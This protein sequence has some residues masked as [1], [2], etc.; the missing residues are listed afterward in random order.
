MAAIASVCDRRGVLCHV[1]GVQ[2]L[3]HIPVDLS[4]IPCD[5]YV[6]ASH[7]F[8]GPRGCGGVFLR[9][10][11]LTPLMDGGTQEWGLRPG[12]EDLPSLA[13]AVAALQRSLA[14]LPTEAPRLRDL[15]RLVLDNVRSSGVACEINGEPDHGLPGL[16]SLTFPGVNGHALVTDL[17][18]QGFAVAS[19]SACSADKPEPS[20]TI[21]ALGRAAD[22]ALGTIRISF[23]RLSRVEDAND[24][25]VAL[26]TAVKRH[27]RGA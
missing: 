4:A 13:G 10:N 27:T 6:F 7:K 15:A 5:F 23:G 21:L 16:V 2:S 20:R 14:L 25:T 24:V 12:T 18:L 26:V 11:G 9:A 19:G 3:G 1:D 17:S 22:A 8:G